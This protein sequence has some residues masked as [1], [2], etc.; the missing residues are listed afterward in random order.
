MF[1]HV[2]ALRGVSTP[3]IPLTSASA[4]PPALATLVATHCPFAYKLMD[5]QGVKTELVMRGPVLATL[6]VTATFCSFWSALLAA[7]HSTPYVEEKRH[8][9]VVATVVVAVLGWTSEDA[10]LVAH[11]WGSS[12]DD[13]NAYG[14]NGCFLLKKDALKVVD[15]CVGILPAVPPPVGG[16]TPTMTALRLRVSPPAV[17][18]KEKKAVKARVTLGHGKNKDTHPDANKPK[19]DQWKQKVSAGDIATITLMGVVCAAIAVV[20]CIFLTRSKPG[21]ASKRKEIKGMKV[22]TA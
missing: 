2:A 1:E 9:K 22:K 19:L 14:Q 13:V 17:G 8:D 18:G 5:S 11:S 4:P 10:W 3:H 7:P 12:V 16:S 20:L 6:H 21:R 15:G